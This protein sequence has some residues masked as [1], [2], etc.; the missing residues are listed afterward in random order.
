MVL[1]HMKVF[2]FTEVKQPA[3]QVR[4]N[5]VLHLFA[6]FDTLQWCQPPCLALFQVF[7]PQAFLT[8][9]HMLVSGTARSLASLQ[10]VVEAFAPTASCSSFT[11][12][13]VLVVPGVLNPKASLKETPFSLKHL[14]TFVSTVLMW[15]LKATAR[16]LGLSP[17]SSLKKISLSHLLHVF[18]YH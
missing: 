13:G 6:P 2:L 1:V 5:K 17:A 18:H 7:Q 9:L 10:M 16:Y 14:L 12:T 15:A 8:S 4:S 3:V 11:L